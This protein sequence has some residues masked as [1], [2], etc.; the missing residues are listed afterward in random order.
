LL[1]SEIFP[2][3]FLFSRCAGQEGHAAALVALPDDTEDKRHL[4]TTRIRA[5]LCK[6]FLVWTG[7]EYKTCACTKVPRCKMDV[8]IEFRVSAA[9]LSSK[10]TVV[11]TEEQDQCVPKLDWSLWRTSTAVS[12]GN[13]AE[14][15]PP[16]SSL[17][18]HL[19]FGNLPSYVVTYT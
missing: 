11:H 17:F 9:F 13:I 2:I 16:A 1:L 18:I 6:Y 10:V 3:L 19:E 12:V 8:N 15:I 4:T 14:V 7:T 5:Q